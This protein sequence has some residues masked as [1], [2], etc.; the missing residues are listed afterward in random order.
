[1]SSAS[2]RL[3]KRNHKQARKEFQPIN[4]TRILMYAREILIILPSDLIDFFTTMYGLNMLFRQ[5]SNPTLL[6]Q[7]EKTLFFLKRCF[8]MY[9]FKVIRQDQD[10][11]GEPPLKYRRFDLILLLTPNI[12]DDIRKYLSDSKE[13]VIVAQE[14]SPYSKFADFLTRVDGK[15]LYEQYFDQSCCTCRIYPSISEFYVHFPVQERYINESRNMLDTL[16]NSRIGK[17]IL[18]D[19][20]TGKGGTKFSDKQIASLVKLASEKV[21]G[22]ILLLDWKQRRYDKL[23]LKSLI[24]KPFFLSGENIELL[25]AHLVNTDIIISP[26]SIFY[27]LAG[28]V[29]TARIGIFMED[30]YPYFFETPRGKAVFVKKFRS[31]PYDE[32]SD[33]MVRLAR[34][35]T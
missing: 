22:S 25:L 24:E 20:S 35:K 5:Y 8:N 13:A 16:D 31:L 7:N 30:E 33:E 1:M 17:T 26:N 18:I 32:I 15:S 10:N 14:Q 19:I 6:V 29:N 3:K 27:H 23:K 21:A 28:L 9:N 2:I 12:S 4:F 11:E 34:A